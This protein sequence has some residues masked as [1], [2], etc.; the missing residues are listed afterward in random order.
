MASPTQWTWVWAS[1]RSCWWPGKPGMLQSVG[2]QRGRHDWPTEQKQQIPE[3]TTNQ[4]QTRGNLVRHLPW[5]RNLLYRR[6]KQNQSTTEA[7]I[8]Y[9]SEVWSQCLFFFCSCTLCPHWGNVW[10]VDHNLWLSYQTVNW[11]GKKI[12]LN[13]LARD[14]NYLSSV[15]ISMKNMRKQN[16]NH[17]SLLLDAIKKAIQPH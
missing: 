4:R 14:A 9:L 17:T 16:K 13:T 1:S 3:H 15:R 11:K 2:L 10:V 5:E 7:C 12:L 8:T 6:G